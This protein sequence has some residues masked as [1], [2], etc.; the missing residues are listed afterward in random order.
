MVQKSPALR[1]KCLQYRQDSVDVATSQ[2]TNGPDAD[3]LRKQADNLNGLAI[4]DPQLAQRLRF[5]KCFP[6]TNTA[7][8]LHYTVFILKMAESLDRPRTAVTIQ[9][10]FAGKEN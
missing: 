8:T 3:A 7:K 9:L 2:A 4:V 10:A 5:G 1:A 6:T